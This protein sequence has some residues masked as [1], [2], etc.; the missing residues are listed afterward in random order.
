M[1]YVFNTHFHLSLTVHNYTIKQGHKKLNTNCMCYT[2]YVAIR[3]C[4]T[5]LPPLLD[6]PE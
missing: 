6:G 4:N 5:N 2:M 3:T 1:M